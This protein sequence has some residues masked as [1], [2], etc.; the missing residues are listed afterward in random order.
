MIISRVFGKCFS[1]LCYTMGNCC[2][3]FEGPGYGGM[4]QPDPEERRRQLAAAAEARLQQ[5]DKRGLKSGSMSEARR[6]QE[7]LEEAE[8]Q[9]QVEGGK[10][11]GLKWQVG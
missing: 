4:D 1:C 7:R 5:G 2:P 3:C 11:E 10:G 8:R 9:Q 6:K